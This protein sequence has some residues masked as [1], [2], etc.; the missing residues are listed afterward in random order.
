M[1]DSP[2]L[3]P[4]V[5]HKLHPKTIDV[6][7]SKANNRSNDQALGVQFQIN[8]SN[9]ALNT[10]PELTFELVL[11]AIPNRVIDVSYGTAQAAKMVRTFQHPVLPLPVSAI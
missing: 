8:N 4:P 11:S 7:P 5:E 9:D 6:V 10:A 2:G 3:R 1:S